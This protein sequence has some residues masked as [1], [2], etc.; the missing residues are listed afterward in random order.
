MILFVSACQESLIDVNGAWF[1]ISKL[2]IYSMDYMLYV[3]QVAGFILWFF[4]RNSGSDI[5]IFLYTGFIH[6]MHSTH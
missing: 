3:I 5:S 2:N 1:Q 6:S 4:L